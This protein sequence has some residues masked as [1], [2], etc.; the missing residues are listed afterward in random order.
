MSQ[1]FNAARFSALLE[2]Y[3]AE[4]RRWPEAER[5]LALDFARAH[6]DAEAEWQAAAHL[7]ALLDSLPA[8]QPVSSREISAVLARLPQAAPALHW[9]RDLWQSLTGWRLAAPAFAF[10]LVAG[11]AS[12]ITLQALTPQTQ[13]ESTSSE[14]T[15]DWWQFSQLQGSTWT[16]LASNP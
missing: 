14:S 7:D 15:P 8:P 5:A 12:G 6:P 1:D 13:T 4:P 2:A 3:G 11:L 10:A 16:Q 9:A